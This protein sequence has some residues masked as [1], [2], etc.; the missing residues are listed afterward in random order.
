MIAN[1]NADGYTWR[2]GSETL[3]TTLRAVPFSVP[4]W[5]CICHGYV[6]RSGLP[7]VDLIIVRWWE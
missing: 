2:K 6:W 3:L 1:L 7:M 5:P 4:C